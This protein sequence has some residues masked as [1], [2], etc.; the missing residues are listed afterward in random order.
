[1]RSQERNIRVVL[2]G[3]TGMIGEGVLAECLTHAAVEKVLLLSRRPSGVEHAKVEEV[4]VADFSDLRA[5]RPLLAGYHACLYCLGSTPLGATEE[6]YRNVTVGLATTLASAL[7]SHP[8]FRTFCFVSAAGADVKGRFMWQRIKGEAEH[9][10]GELKIPS[11][12]V[13]RPGIVRMTKGLRRAHV[14]Y[15]ILDCFL[16]LAK[17]ALPNLICTLRELA[18]AMISAS[19]HG[20]RRT[21]IEV[22]DIER[23]VAGDAANRLLS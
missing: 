3:A 2:T 19:V 9:A 22:P 6:Q 13:F 21:V 5:V 16:P 23:L 7:V 8:S 10:L 17:K 4:I 11:L 20:Y 12:Y 1:M 14:H 15:R 18:L